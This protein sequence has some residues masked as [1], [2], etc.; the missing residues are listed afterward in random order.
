MAKFRLSSDAEEDL[1]RIY[2]FGV[3]NFGERQASIYYDILF[4]YFNII[5]SNPNAFE[6]V[7]QIKPGYRRCPCGSDSIFYRVINDQVEIMRIVGRQ[8]ID[9]LFT[10]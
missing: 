9:T 4:E 5:A 1:V 10:S 7:D 8:D 6:A 3:V 2:G